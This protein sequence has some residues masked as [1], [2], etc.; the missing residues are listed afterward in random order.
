M[1]TTRTTAFVALSAALFAVACDDTPTNPD[2]DGENDAVAEGR[3]EE[4]TPAPSSASGPQQASGTQAQTVSVVH[5]GAS[6]EYSELASADVRADGSY[7]IE[8]VPSGRTNTAV[9]AYVDGRAAGEVLIHGEIRSRATIRPAPITYETTMETRAYARVVAS[10]RAGHTSTSEIALLLRADGSGLETTLSSETEIQA[11]AEGSAEAGATMGEVFADAG[12]ALDAEA[13]GDLLVDAALDLAA[14]L[15][16]GLTLEVAHDDYAEAAIDAFVDAGASL[17]AIVTA[18]AAAASTFDTSIEGRTNIRG[19]LIAEPVLLNFRTRNRTTVKHS[20]SAEGS[21]AA[22][23]ESSLASARASV[24]AATTAAEVRAAL[25]AHIDSTIDAAADAAVEL[26]A[27]DASLT[28]RSNVRAAAVAALEEA[29]LR[30]RLEGSASSS[31]SAAA[32][33]TADYRAAVRG[34][35]QAM[36]DAAEGASADVDVMTSLFIA[37]CGGAHIR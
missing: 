25:E 10:G 29:T 8:G 3:V 20:A 12:V 4:T 32:A 2:F 13:R 9:V 15:I 1:V 26:L 19:R 30:T 27:A 14:D 6:G 22:V 21:V 11:I 28:V 35:V 33:A 34:K 31:A 7:R 24:E 16:A 23:I 37:A 17:D 36:I 18:T 5:I